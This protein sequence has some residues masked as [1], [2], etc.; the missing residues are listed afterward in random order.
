MADSVNTVDKSSAWWNA[1][2]LVLA[3]PP[4]WAGPCTSTAQPPVMPEDAPPRTFSAAPRSR[5]TKVIA[6]TPH[7]A[8][9]AANAAVADYIVAQIRAANLTPKFQDTPLHVAPGQAATVHNV[10]TRIAGTGDTRQAVLL[11]AHYDSVAWGPGAADDGAGVVTLLEALRALRAGPQCTHDIIFLFT[12]GEAG[13]ERIGLPRSVCLRG[14][15]MP[16]SPT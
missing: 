1:T 6:R 15:S 5:H 9:S 14:N 16:G 3:G 11:M 2:L 8:G 13:R 7:P 4:W 10:L 12:D